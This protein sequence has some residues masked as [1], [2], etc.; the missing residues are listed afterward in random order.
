MYRKVITTAAVLCLCSTGLHAENVNFL[1]DYS[2]LTAGGDTGFTK[3]YLAPGAQD[4]I[5]RFGT[6]MVDSPEFFIDPASKY[7]GIKS[8]DAGVVGAELRAALIAGIGTSTTVVADPGE[9]TALISWA[10]T[11]IRLNKKKRGLLGYT[12][13][14]AVAYGAKK[15][16]S[17]IVDKTQAFDVVFELEGTDSN[18]GEVLFA[19]VFDLDAEGVEAEWGNA[20]TLSN[21]LGQR[22]GCRL[23][24]TGLS[25]EKRADCLAIPVHD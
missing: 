22:I 6:V 24:N 8:S 20:I 15:A 13:V 7:K 12:P 10:V 2:K 21:A 5:A 4:A 18:T 16:M 14:G 19:M 17:D 11:N 25:V 23:N 9:G 3:A 1:T